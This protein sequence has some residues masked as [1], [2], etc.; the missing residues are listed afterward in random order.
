MDLIGRVIRMR[1]I[2]FTFSVLLMSCQIARAGEYGEAIVIDGDTLIVK[3]V[4]FELAWI[5]APEIGQECQDDKRA[6]KCGVVAR[7]QLMDLT[8]GQDVTCHELD[9][10]KAQCSAGGYDLSEGMAYTGWAILV[11]GASQRL[12]RVSTEAKEKARGLWRYQFM[13]PAAWRKGQRDVN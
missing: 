4:T 12:T 5:D 8:A 13:T 2:L 7:A 11:Q 3:G 6:I 10:G 1:G 9:N